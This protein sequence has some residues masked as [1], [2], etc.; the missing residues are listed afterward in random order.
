MFAAYE[1]CS[2][3]LYLKFAI[4]AAGLIAILA[5]PAKAQ[6]PVDLNIV[7]RLQTYAIPFTFS[8]SDTQQLNA[9]TGACL[10]DANYVFILWHSAGLRFDDKLFAGLIV[11]AKKLT[12]EAQE[13]NK[14]KNPLVDDL[15][16]RP[17]YSADIIARFLSVPGNVKK[18][19]LA[20]GEAL[21]NPTVVPY[22]IQPFATP[23]CKAQTVV[24]LSGLFN[25]TFETNVL[26]NN[27]NNSPGGSWGGGGNAQ[28]I[29]PGVGKFDVV[30]LSAQEQSVRYGGYASKSFDAI[31]SQAAYQFFVNAGGYKSEGGWV[32]VN[33]DTH[34]PDVPPSNLIT[35]ASVALGVQNQTVFSP[36]FHAETLDLATPQVTF[37]L[38]NLSLAGDTRCN[39]EIPD[40]RK[41]GFCF[42][43]GVSLTV[44]Q[45]FADIGS[46]Q[47][48]NIALSATP[49]WRIDKSD[50]TLTLPVTGT[51]RAYEE[52]VGGRDDFLLQIGPS[53]SYSPQPF[54]LKTDVISYAFSLSATY[55]QNFST[56]PTAAWRGWIIMP[57]FTLAFQPPP[58]VK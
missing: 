39:L 25:P 4:A 50:F 9:N 21:S 58:A 44:G 27:L 22:Y 15:K 52:V 17:Q 13:A 40:P 56:I 35:V 11:D 12:R 43:T 26:K 24:K 5:T 29:A 54:Y 47:N 1:F 53:L 8:A 57:S 30:G 42:F 18:A 32:P 38:Q 3:N 2:R 45:S 37:N 6:A 10:D 31:T 23:Y 28:F 20:S 33:A 34:A 55:N 16:Q 49:G 48:A 36:T 41:A 14:K 19:K 46:Q 7:S 51:Y